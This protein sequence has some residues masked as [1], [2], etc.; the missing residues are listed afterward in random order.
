VPFQTKK[1]HYLRS[2]GPKNLFLPSKSTAEN[3]RKVLKPP[4]GGVKVS[5]RNFRFE[6]QRGTELLSVGRF[7]FS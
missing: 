7:T 2:T 6:K 5:L 1:K 3:R 4:V